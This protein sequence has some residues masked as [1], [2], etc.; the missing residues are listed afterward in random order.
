MKIF[1]VEMVRAI[2]DGRK[3]VTRRPIKPQ[4][5]ENTDCPYH[6]GIGENRKARTL[7]YRPG[8]TVYVK[9]D[10]GVE[11]DRIKLEI[12]SVRPERL[13]EIS[14]EDAKHEGFHSYGN[15]QLAFQAC[16][17]SIYA[18]KYPWDSNPWVWRI[19]FEVIGEKD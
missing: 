3:T 2:L 6:T 19:E 12:V 18:D 13:Q 16:W 10:W 5:E 8:E 15:A 11:A 17:D 4:P 14:R 7:P 9:E 1:N